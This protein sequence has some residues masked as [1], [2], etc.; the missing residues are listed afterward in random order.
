MRSL[1]NVEFESGVPFVI[2]LV[3][4]VELG[5]APNKLLTAELTNRVGFVSSLSVLNLSV[6]IWSRRLIIKA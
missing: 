3:S 4:F 5:S 6:P 2:V 1:T